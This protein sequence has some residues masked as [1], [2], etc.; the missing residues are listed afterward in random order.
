MRLPTL[1]VLVALACLLAEVVDRLV[2]LLRST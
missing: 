2:W 1:V